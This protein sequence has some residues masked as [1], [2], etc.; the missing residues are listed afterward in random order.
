[1]ADARFLS[2]EP[3]VVIENIFDR[4]YENAVATAR[5]CYSSR[6]II[7]PGQVS[8][9]DLDDPELR[10]K[11]IDQRDSIAESIYQAG[12]HTTLQHCYIQFRLANVSRQFIW[13]FLHSHPYYNSEQVSQRY[14]RVSPGNVAVP[15]LEGEALEVFRKTVECQIEY[16]NQLIQALTPAV[17]EEYYRIFPGRRDKKPYRRDIRRKAQEVARYV[18]PVAT[19]AYLYHTVSVV[20]LLRYRRIC[21]SFDAPL[22]QRLVVEKMVEAL[23]R[24]DPLCERLVE[25]PLSITE[26]PEAELFL[27]ATN[28]GPERSRAFASEFDESLQGRTSRL[29]DYK[30]RNEECLAEAVREVF[31]LSRAELSDDEAIARVLDPSRNPYLGRSLNLATHSKLMRALH[32]PG[33]TFRKKLSHTADSQ[34]QRHRTVPASR[35]CLQ[36]MVGDEPDIIEPELVR[37]NPGLRALYHEAMER[38]WDGI[39]RL[40]KLGAS[41][42]FRAYLLPNATAIRFTESAD[43]LNLHHKMEMRLCYNAQEEIWRACVDEA[44]EITR[45]NPRIGRFLLPPCT[46][47]D[48]SKAHPICPEGDRFCGVPVW[49]LDLSEYR[50]VL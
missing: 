25:E 23:L 4:P 45:V 2:A 10:Q 46:L 20:T 50:R 29:V 18:L 21:E 24:R 7:L 39:S 12:H 27:M 28:S 22:E 47:R 31:G 48:L 19:F 40:G 35:P 15:P 16:Y 33:Y 30:I 3:E 1:V 8:G 36:A 38:T 37:R 34:D 13:S 11:R 26:T 41:A 5:T 14:V 42:E 44:M 43:L 17:E 32:H 6:G 9:D 49:R